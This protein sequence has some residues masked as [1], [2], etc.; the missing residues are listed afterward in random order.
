MHEM[1][2]SNTPRWI[3]KKPTSALLRRAGRTESEDS[4]MYGQTAKAETA[5]KTEFLRLSTETKE[6]FH[7]KEESVNK[8]HPHHV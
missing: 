4:S 7:V 5:F 8:R 1:A 2:A 3:Y 6:K